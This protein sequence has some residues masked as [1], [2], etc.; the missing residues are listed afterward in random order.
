MSISLLSNR[1]IE[2]D[3]RVENY[4]V[5]VSIEVLY[6]IGCFKNWITG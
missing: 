4:E 3:S 2:E 6:L 1:G 5:V